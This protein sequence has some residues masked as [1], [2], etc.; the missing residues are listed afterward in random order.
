MGKLKDYFYNKKLDKWERMMK[1]V[2]NRINFN[3]M[4]AKF[5]INNY[6]DSDLFTRRIEEY[7]TWFTG[8]SI[9]IRKFY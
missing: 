3:P 8:N 4:R 5:N 2:Q 7:K 6:L 1:A 9:I